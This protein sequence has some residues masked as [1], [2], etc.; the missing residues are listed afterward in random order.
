M[1][2]E[3]VEK[4]IGDYVAF[5]D[6]KGVTVGYSTYRKKPSIKEIKEM[7]DIDVPKDR[8]YPSN[9]S[10]DREEMLLET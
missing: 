2:N 4:I 5:R 6:N 3:E 10:F 1:A 9:Q 8:K 7:L